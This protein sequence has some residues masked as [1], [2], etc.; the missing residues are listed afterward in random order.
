MQANATNG[1]I[2][3]MKTKPAAHGT[4]PD[5]E[6]DLFEVAVAEE[7]ADVVHMV[8]PHFA[9]ACDLGILEVIRAGAI[10][11]RVMYTLTVAETTCP[12][13]L[14]AGDLHAL[15]R[16]ISGSQALSEA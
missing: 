9:T 12:E 6:L 11:G 14:A 16:E 10:T 8:L 2:S 4:K 15:C 13:C 3:G 7:G 1:T 5:R